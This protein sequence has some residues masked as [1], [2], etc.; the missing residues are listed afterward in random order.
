MWGRHGTHSI[1]KGVAY[2]GNKQSCGTITI[3]GTVYWDGSSYQNGG[4]TYLKTSPLEY[5]PQH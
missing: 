1:G 4:D 5:K 2:N 3:G